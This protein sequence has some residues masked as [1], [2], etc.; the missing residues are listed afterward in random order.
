MSDINIVDHVYNIW[1]ERFGGD[2]SAKFSAGDVDDELL[3]L[4]AIY[5]ADYEG[6]FEFLVS[7]K[8][9]IDAGK[10]MSPG[11]AKGILNCVVAEAKRQ[12]NIGGGGGT[13]IAH[14]PAPGFYRVTVGA[15]TDTFR[16]RDWTPQGTDKK[17]LMVSAQFVPESDN[18]W[19][20]VAV[21]DPIAKTYNLRKAVTDEVIR[22]NTNALLS[23]S[24]EELKHM[25]APYP[26]AA[27]T[28][29]DRFAF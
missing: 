6:D 19:T 14:V 23:A 11:I 27:S 9:D 18:E 28:P 5:L 3:S 17:L 1:G 29:A 2:T 21:I 4:A 7:V 8:Q 16:I 15:Y 25:I 13:P 20:M 22:A 24:P 12:R 26:A 10:T